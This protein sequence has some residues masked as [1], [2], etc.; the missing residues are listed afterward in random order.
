MQDI[1][2]TLENF[3]LGEV[4]AAPSNHHDCDVRPIQV[5][6]RYPL[7]LAAPLLLKVAVLQ[8]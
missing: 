2:S 3:Q 4:P 1:M 8:Q 6:V 7:C 5:D